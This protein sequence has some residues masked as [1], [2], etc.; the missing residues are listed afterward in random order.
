MVSH[1][2]LELSFEVR[3]LARQPSFQRK[4][5]PEA[6]LNNA[7]KRSIVDAEGPIEQGK[8]QEHLYNKGI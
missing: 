3:S 2:L 7:T 1:Q 5:G 6:A 4:L 8:R